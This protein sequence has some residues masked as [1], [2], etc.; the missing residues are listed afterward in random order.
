[1]VLQMLGFGFILFT[2]IGGALFISGDFR[3]AA[4]AQA[5]HGAAR[6]MVAHHRRALNGLYVAAAHLLPQQAG[7]RSHP[8]PLN[9]HLQA[10]LPAR[11]W[12]PRFPDGCRTP[13]RAC[14]PAGLVR[15]LYRDR[16]E[17]V[18]SAAPAKEPN[19]ILEPQSPRLGRHSQVTASPCL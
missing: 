15:R 18:G 11:C 8:E 14:A 12:S 4:Q 9:P 3:P 17:Q 7:A 13:K 6:V 19:P 16:S 1:V 5:S 10:V 2:L